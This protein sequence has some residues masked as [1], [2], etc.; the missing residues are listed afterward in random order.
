[1][2]AVFLHPGAIETL[3][4]TI[5]PYLTESAQGP[6]LIC[7]ELDTGGALCEMLL[8]GKDADGGVVEVELMLPLGM[9]L[10]VVSVRQDGGL[11]GFRGHAVGDAPP[12]A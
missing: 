2:Y 1:M 11:F 12:A 10:L 5:K 3:G 8:V 4:E 9:I 7:A 6:H